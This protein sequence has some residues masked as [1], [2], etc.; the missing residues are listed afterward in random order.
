LLVKKLQ[1]EL[2]KQK[3]KKMRYAIVAVLSAILCVFGCS[4]PAGTGNGTTAVK[5]DHDHDH[6]HDH[7]NSGEESCCQIGPNGGTIFKFENPEYLGEFAESKNK[8][9]FRFYILNAKEEDAPLKVDRFVIIPEAGNDSTPIEIEVDSPDAEG[10][11][12]IYFSDDKQL[13]PALR[14]GARV[15]IHAGDLVLSGHVEAHEHHGH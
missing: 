9:S 4:N 10:R 11:S 6:D 2:K 12:H 13:K 3:E 15:E 7:E 1:P 5:H 8:D 14:T